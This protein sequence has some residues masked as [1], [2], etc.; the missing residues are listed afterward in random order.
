MSPVERGAHSSSQEAPRGG[1]RGMVCV[2]RGGI[3]QAQAEASAALLLGFRELST[4]YPQ[5][6]LELT[7]ECSTRG[8]APLRTIGRRPV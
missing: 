6:L 7:S 1:N 8:P 5:A 2:S 3:V 4:N